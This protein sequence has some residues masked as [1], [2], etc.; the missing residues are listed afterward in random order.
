MGIKVRLYDESRSAALQF[1]F[2]ALLILFLFV[3]LG[4][5][6]RADLASWVER[7]MPA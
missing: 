7:I 2:F 3:A 5:L 1:S 4:V 6:G